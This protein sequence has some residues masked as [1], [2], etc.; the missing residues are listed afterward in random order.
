MQDS[1]GDSAIALR[2]FESADD[3]TTPLAE[4]YVYYDSCF[5]NG[6]FDSAGARQLTRANCRPLFARPPIRLW[7]TQPPVTEVCAH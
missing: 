3:A 5:G 7:I 1:Y 4:A 6:I 2:F